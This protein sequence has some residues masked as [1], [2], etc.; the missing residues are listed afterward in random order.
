MNLPKKPE[1][2]AITVVTS[3]ATI[4][5][6]FKAG[7]AR[8]ALATTVTRY[9]ME[10]ARNTEATTVTRNILVYEILGERGQ[11]LAKESSV[12]PVFSQPTT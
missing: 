4:V 6:R 10:Y 3:F 12:T 5:R 2:A 9:L 1:I 7:Y 11:G 8:H